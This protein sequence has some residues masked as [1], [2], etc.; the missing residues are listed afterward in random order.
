MA[1]HAVLQVEDTGM[2]IDAGH[3]SRIFEPFF[4]GKFT[5]RCAGA[6]R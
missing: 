4:S 1:P 3:L 5:G 2:G 6:R